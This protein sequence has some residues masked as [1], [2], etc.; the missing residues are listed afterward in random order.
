VHCNDSSPIRRAFLIASPPARLAGVAAIVLVL[1]AA[2]TR[3]AA[4]EPGAAGPPAAPL[5]YTLRTI[6]S[7]A[8][9]RIVLEFSRKPIYEI[10]G[11]GDRVFLT[12][13]EPVVEP[14]FKKRDYDGRVLDKVK[15]VEGHRASEVVFYAGEE[16]AT[17]AVF[18]MGE[19]FRIVLDLRRKKGPPIATPIPGAGGGAP[20]GGAAGGAPGG[21][22]GGAPGATAAPHGGAAAPAAPAAPAPAAASS[23]APVEP[24]VKKRFTVVVDPGHGGED[25][26]ARGPSGLAEKDVTLD[27][28]RRLKAR[29]LAGMDADVLLTR[30]ADRAVALDERTAIANH[31]RADL[32]V[33]IHANATRRGQAEGAETYFLSYQET[34]DDSRAVAAIE[35]NTLGLEEGVKANSS[36]EM[37][38]WDLAQSAFL[39]ESSALAEIIQGNLNDALGINNRGIKQAPFR[40]LMGATMPAVLVEIGFITNPDEERR[41]RDAAFKDRLAA[42]IFESVRRYHDRYQADRPR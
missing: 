5:R 22:A 6:D 37:I 17:F 16:F 34:D 38:L 2:A 23:E 18:E 26:G 30:E 33:S 25:T 29:I 15:F 7:E 3:A 21:A 1:G 14:P 11:E 4:Q 20:A 42:A 31:Q 41:L 40:V 27:V 12:L 8:G 32:F 35:N 39:K 13:R 19:P 9:T 24:V 36:L 10:R 28:A